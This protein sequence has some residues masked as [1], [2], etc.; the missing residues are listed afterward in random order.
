MP[1]LLALLADRPEAPTFKHALDLYAEGMDDRAWAE[2]AKHGKWLPISADRGQSNR[3]EKL[4]R[5]FKELG[6]V[7]IQLSGQVHSL[8][9]RDK[10]L[11]IAACWMEIEQVWRHQV[12]CTHSLRLNDNGHGFRLIDVE[13]QR[14][15]R[16]KRAP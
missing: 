12:G 8:P 7:N 14:A 15:K 11:A 9:A 1:P 5:I 4:P 6:L 2:A 3:G 16:A 10:V 13:A